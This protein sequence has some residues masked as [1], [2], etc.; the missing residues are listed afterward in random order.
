MRVRLWNLSVIRWPDASDVRAAAERW[1]AAAADEH[2][3]IVRVGYFGSY[4]RGDWGVGSDIDLV[5][6]V[7]HTQ[8]PFD[9]RSA[10]WDL[11]ALPVPSD[12]LV[13]TTDEFARLT[14]E[15]KFGKMLEQETVWVF[16]STA[17]PHGSES[18][19]ATDAC[20]PLQP[21]GPTL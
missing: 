11:S 18:A 2:P 9:R 14:R 8:V 13:Y 6:V 19:G 20:N 10:K 15:G 3:E 1:A 7:D 16:P 5:M 4:A 21:P 12:L 17:P